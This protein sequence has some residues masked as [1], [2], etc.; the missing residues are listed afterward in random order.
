MYSINTLHFIYYFSKN[1]P[2]QFLPLSFQHF[3]ALL[4]FC[5]A[6]W[7]CLFQASLLLHLSV[8]SV[9][10]AIPACLSSLFCLFTLSSRP[11]PSC[12]CLLP[13]PVYLSLKS[14]MSGLPVPH[15]SYPV[16][17]FLPLSFQYF[18]ALL[19]SCPAFWCCHFP[20]KPFAASSCLLFPSVAACSTVPTLCW[21]PTT[22]PTFLL[23]PS[24]SPFCCLSLFPSL[25]ATY[26]LCPYQLFLLHATPVL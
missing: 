26:L 9:L 16:F 10:S 13:C 11:Q 15:L 12:L 1:N 2:F 18:L 19:M 8:L 3:L 25:S 17:Q 14:A 23:P 24:F 4:L 5:P 21:G 22:F 6:F 7:C 20:D